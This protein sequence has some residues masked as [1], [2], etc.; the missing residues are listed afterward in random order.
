MIEN[1]SLDKSKAFCKTHKDRQATTSCER[2]GDFIC[3][4][5]SRKLDSGKFCQD[6]QIY[7][8]GP[9]L[10]DLRASLW[11][12]RDELV[13]LLGGFGSL[14]L[15]I[16]SVLLVAAAF[17]KFRGVSVGPQ[18][19]QMLFA[20]AFLGFSSFVTMAYFML[21]KWAR[22]ALFLVLICGILLSII[23]SLLENT[24]DV[25]T[26]VQVLL[27]GFLPFTFILAA[28]LSPRN[29][30]AFKIDISIEDL[31]KIYETVKVNQDARNSVLLSLLG[32]LLPPLLLASLYCAYR[33]FKN[34]NPDSSP[35]IPGLKQ[36]LIGLTLSLI[37]ILFWS[38]FFVVLQFR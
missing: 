38:T 19:I 23:S 7:H 9:D 5:C 12:K 13:W 3:N 17:E 32:F 11:G 20:A 36:A 22:G 30:L 2:C 14:F 24:L 37:G 21:Q 10:L 35:P 16:F 31:G 27:R 34:Y 4:E 25:T 28:F 15:I 18:I 26:I 6:C 8:G 1:T 29:K 33:G